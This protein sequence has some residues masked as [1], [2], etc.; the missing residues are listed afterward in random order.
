[1]G[2]DLSR[3]VYGDE[4]LLIHAK[5]GMASRGKLSQISDRKTFETLVFTGLQKVCVLLAF[6]VCCVDKYHLLIVLIY[7]FLFNTSIKVI[8][9]F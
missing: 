6:L 2:G 7:V 3:L 1:M 9:I 4:H 8:D 5:K